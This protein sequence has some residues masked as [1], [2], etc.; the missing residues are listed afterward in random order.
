MA[1]ADFPS[2][3]Q[4]IIQQNMLEREFEEGLTSKLAYSQMAD[5][6]EFPNNVGE[7]LTKTKTGYLT[8]TETPVNP[9]SNSGLNNGQTPQY[10]AVEQ[11]TMTLQ[12]YAI[13]TDLNV[14]TQKV[15]IKKRFLENTRKLG[16]NARQ[17][18][19]RLVRNAAF[20]AYMG[21]NSRVIVTLLAP[22]TS[23]QVDD[24][25]GFQ[26]IVVQPNSS[27]PGSGTVQPVSPSNPLPVQVGL[28]IYSVIGFSND[29]VNVSTAFRGTSGTL[30]FSTNVT[31][32]DAT[33]GNPVVSSFAPVIIRP[34]TRATTYNL[35]SNDFLTMQM[36]LD[37]NAV[38]ENNAVPK[39]DGKYNMT[40]DNI[41]ARQLFAD[42]EF[43]LL[44][45]GTGDTTN[46]Y[47]YAEIVEFLDFRLIKTTEAP[48]QSLINS[49]SQPIRVHRPILYGEG[50]IQEGRFS[51]LTDET[52][53]MGDNSNSEIVVVEGVAAVT[54]PPLDRLK[55]IVSQSWYSIKGFAVPTDVTASTDIIPTA[56]NSYFKRAVLFE[57]GSL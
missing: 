18:M 4:D 24:T 15:G 56:N 26:T 53:N 23:V 43:Q 11:Y 9:A 30:I 49:A 50:A 8:P 17:S 48:Q 16:V 25:R 6:E 38:L 7:T 2:D 39:I 47:K 51:G 32:A 19:D 44:Y 42:P 5:V 10:W 29:P 22:G 3:L 45:R 13:T 33:L 35:L 20:D 31:I 57:L 1:I 41:S 37:A 52:Q 28:N 40:L 34:N 21:G 46:A 54:R 14:V 55:Q 36:L 12:L 27:N